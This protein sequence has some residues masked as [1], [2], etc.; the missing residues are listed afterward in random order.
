MIYYLAMEKKYYELLEL[1]GLF[2][3]FTQCPHCKKDNNV[4]FKM[5]REVIHTFGGTKEGLRIP[6]GV[7][8]QRISRD[9]TIWKGLKRYR[10]S[11][12]NASAQ[13]KEYSERYD[14][15]VDNVN[16]IYTNIQKVVDKYLNLKSIYTKAKGGNRDTTRIIR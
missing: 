13:A 12:L 7:E 6:K 4:H 5:M 10:E 14:I 15:T 3:E 9:L 8:L 2:H 11:S 16:K 1:Y